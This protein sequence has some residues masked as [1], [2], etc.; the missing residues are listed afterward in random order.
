MHKF[1]PTLTCPKCD[2][3]VVWDKSMRYGEFVCPTCGERLRLQMGAPNL[4][5]AIGVLAA[6]LVPLLAGARGL[7]LGVLALVLVVPSV[8]AVS[9]LLSFLIRPVLIASRP[10]ESR[11]RYRKKQAIIT[12]FDNQKPE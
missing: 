2:S 5:P 9:F 3:V 6:V 1:S 12:L 8:G 7:R 4:I 11:P 10:R